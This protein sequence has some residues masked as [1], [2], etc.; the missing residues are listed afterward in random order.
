M[1]TLRFPKE[2]EPATEQDA[3]RRRVVQLRL[4]IEERPGG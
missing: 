3:R 4:L 1:P 2:A